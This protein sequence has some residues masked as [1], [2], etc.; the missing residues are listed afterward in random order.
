MLDIYNADDNHLKDSIIICEYINKIVRVSGMNMLSRINVIDIPH[1]KDCRDSGGVTA[2]CIIEE[3][4]ISVHTFPYKKFAS[5]DIYT[6]KEGLD[7]QK[8]IKWTT[9]LF[10]GE[11][12]INIAPILIKRGLKF[13]NE[14][15]A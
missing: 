7:V 4:H 1:K 15:I 5:V 6:C 3:S 14:D 8:I 13:P 2:F 11:D 12:K 10:K 9:L